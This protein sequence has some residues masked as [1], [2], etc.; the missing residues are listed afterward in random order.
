M[1]EFMRKAEHVLAALED[2][3]RIDVC[4]CSN[5]E[6]RLRRNLDPVLFDNHHAREIFIFNRLAERRWWQ[7]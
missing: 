2:R 6:R 1:S 5:A 3:Y 7:W 4:D